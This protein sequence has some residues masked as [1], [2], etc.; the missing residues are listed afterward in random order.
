MNER[1]KPASLGAEVLLLKQKFGEFQRQFEDLRSEI[2]AWMQQRQG[3]WKTLWPV[4]VPVAGALW[5]ILSLKIDQT[6]QPIR[7]DASRAL[8]MAEANTISLSKVAEVLPTIMQQNASSKQDRDD[9]KAIVSKLQEV[10][11]R[12]LETQAKETAER[13]ANEREVETQIDAVAQAQ[14]IQFSNQ[15]RANA[16]LQNALHD[17]GA[18][19]PAAPPGPF[20]FPNISNRNH[21]KQR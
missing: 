18:K 16:D 7:N 3:T 21:R 20:Y 9:Q 15:Q 1:P 13:L 8:S 17:M 14:A 12:I 6:A 2:H 4:V 11:T 19:M 5:F 10:Q